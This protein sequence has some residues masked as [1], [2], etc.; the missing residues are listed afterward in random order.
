MKSCAA[1]VK[2]ENIVRNLLIQNEAY[3]VLYLKISGGKK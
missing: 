2:I 1:E 3:C